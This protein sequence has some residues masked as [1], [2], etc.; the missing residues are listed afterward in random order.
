M[1]LPLLFPLFIF[2]SPSLSQ[3]SSFWLTYMKFDSYDPQYRHQAGG[4]FTTPQ[5]PPS[6]QCDEATYDSGIWP[7]RDDVSGDKLG[8]RFDPSDDVGFPLYR[9]P[10]EVIEFNTGKFWA[11]HQSTYDLSAGRISEGASDHVNFR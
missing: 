3:P 2:S 11:G 10:L 5:G 6:W 1:F 7:D 9:D 8:I 4:V